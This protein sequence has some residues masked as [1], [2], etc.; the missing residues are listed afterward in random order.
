[1]VS[2][3]SGK[4]AVFVV[5]AHSVPKVDQRIGSTLFANNQ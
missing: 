2:H 4:A 3:F 5:G 1:M